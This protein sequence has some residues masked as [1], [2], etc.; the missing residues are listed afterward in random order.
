M[1]Y[2][3]WCPKFDPVLKHLFNQNS[4][5]SMWVMLI[6]NII[7]KNVDHEVK[8][9]RAY[10][11][12]GNLTPTLNICR[13]WGKKEERASLPQKLFIFLIGIALSQYKDLSIK[14]DHNYFLII[15]YWLIRRE[16]IFKSNHI[17]VLVIWLVYIKK[18]WQNK[19]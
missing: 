17:E 15:S 13:P 12:L 16:K 6:L 19:S 3:K 4:T 14:C 7:Q 1:F 10:I 18:V 5:L 11:L 2:Q 9:S 8:T